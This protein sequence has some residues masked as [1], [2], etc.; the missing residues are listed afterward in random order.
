M[1]LFFFQRRVRI[2]GS[3]GRERLGCPAVRPGKGKTILATEEAGIK[4]QKVSN[5]E[6]RH[7]VVDEMSHPKV[8]CV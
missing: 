5:S 8:G 6:W 1:I 3:L 2:R 4:Q 7:H